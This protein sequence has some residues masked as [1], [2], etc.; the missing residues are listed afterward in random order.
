MRLNGHV[1]T[2]LTKVSSAIVQTG[3]GK[4]RNRVV[5]HSCHSPQMASRAGTEKDLQQHAKETA[6]LRCSY[7][8]LDA[9]KRR[10]S[11][12]SKMWC[13]S[14]KGCGEGR[15]IDNFSVYMCHD[16]FLH[17]SIPLFH[18]TSPP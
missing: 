18:P 8:M 10:I 11:S 7:S 2:K 4:V 9:M 14:V 5:K 13:M 1:G 6:S 12:T 3:G 17:C 15:G 16:P